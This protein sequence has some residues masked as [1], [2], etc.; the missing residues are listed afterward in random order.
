MATRKNLV[1]L[2]ALVALLVMQ[3]VLTRGGMAARMLH[4]GLLVA[5]FLGMVL[6]V[7]RQRGERRLAFVLIVP[8]FA[9]HLAQAFVPDR[10][11]VPSAMVFHAFIVALICFAVAVILRE[12]TRKRVVRGD[13]VLGAISGYILV[14]ILWGN[15]YVVTELLVPGSFAVQPEIAWQ[16]QEWSLRRALFNYFSFATLTS[17]GYNDIT[18]TAPLADTLTWLEVIFGQ[19]YMAVVVAQL[20]GMKLAQA[21]RPDGP[22]HK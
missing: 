6:T 22:E 16:L 2:V 9:I 14:G 7:F 17:L 19:F 11:H 18:S 12:I 8:A 10:L 1:V 5:V 21:I 13:D 4:E 15:L 3:P 20:V